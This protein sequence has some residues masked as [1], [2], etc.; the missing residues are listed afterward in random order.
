MRS[1]W[2]VRVAGSLWCSRRGI[3]R[4]TSAAS[5]SVVVDGRRVAGRRRSPGRS[6]GRTAPRRS[7][8][9]PPPAP[10]RRPGPG[11]RAAVSPLDWSMRMSSGPGRRNEKPRSPAV[12]LRRRHAQVHQAAVQRQRPRL[13][14]APRASR[15]N[16][17]CT[18]VTRSPKRR[19]VG[20][21]RRQ[22]VLVAVE[23]EQPPVGRAGVQDRARVP[24]VAD[25][26]VAVPPARPGRQPRQHL[27]A[28]H[29]QV[30]PRGRRPRR[31]QASFWRGRGCRGPRPAFRRP[32]GI[33]DV[34]SRLQ[35]MGRHP[36][37][38]RRLAL[39]TFRAGFLNDCDGMT[40]GSGRA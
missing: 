22:R 3:A 8:A 21:R 1:A 18:S 34:D 14:P 23:T 35:D 39:S 7:R 29:R 26:G 40:V 4:A 25:R 30:G 38:R 15:E 27:V 5:A 28:Q 33:R 24:A 12:E 17:A 32:E 37:F 10:P 36:I 9:A 16:G 13:P 11:T 31:R 20:P 19:Q 2:N 6:A